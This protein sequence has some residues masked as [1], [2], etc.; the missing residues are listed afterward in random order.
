MPTN[1]ELIK[2]IIWCDDLSETEYF[3]QGYRQ[4][5]KNIKEKIKEKLDN[6]YSDI[7]A[8]SG[9]HIPVSAEQI[10]RELFGDDKN[11]NK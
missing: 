1:E 6:K 9:N 5:E 8:W 10:I 2:N 4:A 11:V 3:L 7:S